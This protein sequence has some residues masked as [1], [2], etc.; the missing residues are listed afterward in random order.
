MEGKWNG[1]NGALPVIWGPSGKI[2]NQWYS[3]RTPGE[4]RLW[5]T[6]KA[7]IVA[8]G[9]NK[10]CTILMN[11]HLFPLI[12]NVNNVMDQNKHVK[13]VFE[14][15]KTIRILSSTQ[16]SNKAA[17]N[18]STTHIIK[19]IC[20]HKPRGEMIT[21][22]KIAFQIEHKIHRIFQKTE[23]RSNNYQIVIQWSPTTMKWIIGSTKLLP[24]AH[25]LPREMPPPSSSRQ[26]I[27]FTRPGPR[28]NI[29]TVLSTY[30]N[31][32]VKDKTA[33]RTSYV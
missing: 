10:S 6:I 4:A 28:L 2:W 13:G 26:D 21:K 24:K 17:Q 20:C 15:S 18:I 14:I 22:I 12:L 3:K 11:F 29:K 5:H 31:F 9:S 33:V 23:N 27:P 1:T 32:H 16:R 25:D 19:L 30:G 8:S 7:G